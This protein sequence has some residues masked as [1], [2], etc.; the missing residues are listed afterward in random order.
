MIL[1]EFFLAFRGIDWSSKDSM[2]E[3]EWLIGLIRDFE[4]TATATSITG[5]TG[6]KIA[7]KWRTACLCLEMTSRKPWRQILQRMKTCPLTWV[8]NS[9]FLLFFT[10]TGLRPRT[11]HPRSPL[12]VPIQ[13]GIVKRKTKYLPKVVNNKAKQEAIATRRWWLEMFTNGKKNWMTKLISLQCFEVRKKVK[14]KIR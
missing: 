3:N 11:P 12:Q 9:T 13:W 5:A 1:V 7:Q 8:N 2:M 14:N 4:Q 10:I 6:S